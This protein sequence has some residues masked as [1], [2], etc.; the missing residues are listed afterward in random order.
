M[1]NYARSVLVAVG[2]VFA[3][4]FCPGAQSDVLARHTRNPRRNLQGWNFILWQF[5]EGRLLRSWRGK[6]LEYKCSSSHASGRPKH[7]PSHRRRTS[8]SRPRSLA[9]VLDRSG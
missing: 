8:R 6:G 5:K 4:G 3:L 1:N 7:P 2:V 9:A